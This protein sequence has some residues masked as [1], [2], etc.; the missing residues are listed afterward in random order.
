MQIFW[1]RSESGE[2]FWGP[3]VERSLAD[4]VLKIACMAGYEDAEVAVM[5][6]DQNLDRIS[7]GLLPWKIIAELEDGKLMKTSCS[8]TWPPEA[9]EGIVRGEA[10]GSGEE[11]RQIEY[12]VWSKTENEA[13]RRLAQ[14]S[15]APKAK[16]KAEA[17]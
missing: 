13:K 8:L 3:Y 4:R 15:S 7:A 9:Q 11:A 6:C 14:L 10:D 5:D 17:S 1:V 12:F 16:A 2:D